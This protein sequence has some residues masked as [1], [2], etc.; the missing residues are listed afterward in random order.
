MGAE[1]LL[2]IGLVLVAVS[3]I[4]AWITNCCLNN[5]NLNP[6]IKIV[7]SIISLITVITFGMGFLSISVILL[8]K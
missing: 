1:S 2:I 5:I 8:L 6:K 7:L 3:A 4:V